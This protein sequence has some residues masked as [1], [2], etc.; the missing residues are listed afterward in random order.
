MRDRA[1]P[2][3]LEL[4]SDSGRSFRISAEPSYA[5]PRIVF[6]RNIAAVRDPQH[7]AT[8]VYRVIS[9]EAIP[10]IVER[11]AWA[12]MTSR[13]ALISALCR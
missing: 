8:G 13:A 3:Q 2:S 10:E 9:L 1:D 6:R 4:R 5:F 12:A 7:C 11:S